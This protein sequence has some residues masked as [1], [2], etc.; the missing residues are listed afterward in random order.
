MSTQNFIPKMRVRNDRIASIL[1]TTANVLMVVAIGTLP[2]MAIGAK[3]VPVGFSKTAV[4]FVACLLALICICLS[5]LRTGAMRLRMPLVLVS[6]WAVTAVSG[7]SALLSGDRR[8]AFTGDAFEVHTVIFLCVMALLATLATQFSSSTL[9][10]L[11]LYQLSLISAAALGLFHVIRV[12]FGA[13]VLSFGVYSGLLGSPLG[14]WNDLAIFFGIVLILSLISL[15]QIPLKTFGKILTVFMTVTSLL[16]LSLVNFYAV[17]IVV[18]LF[19]LVFLIYTLT[20]DRFA[21]VDEAEG[22]MFVATSS[23]SVMSISL[24]AIVFIF[25]TM[26][27]L[28]GSMLGGWISEKT[29]I[30]YVE[31]RPSFT[32][33]VDIIKNI[34]SENAFTGIGPNKFSDAWNLYKDPSINNTIFWNSNFVSGNGYVMTWFA[35]AGIFGGVAWIIFFGLFIY[36]GYRLLVRSSTEDQF[37]YFVGSTSFVTALFVWVMAFWY[38]PGPALLLLGAFST[39]LMAAAT[40]VL[41]PEIKQPKLLFNNRRSGFILIAAVMLVMIASVAT[42]FMTGKQYASVYTYRSAMSSTAIDH[43]KLLLGIQSAYELYENDT[44]L[45]QI[46]RLETERLAYIASMAEP[47][48]LNIQQASQA[49]IN[50]INNLEAA[51]SFDPSQSMNWALLSNFY[52]IIA[53]T[54]GNQATA[55]NERAEQAINRAIELQPTN[56]EFQLLKAQIMIQRGDTETARL[57]VVK[58]LELKRDYTPALSL[59]TQLDIASGNVEGAITNARSLITLEPRNAGRYY[60]LG[61]LLSSNNNLDGAIEAFSQAIS[62]DNGYANARYMLALAL[63]QKGEKEAA[64]EQL[65]IVRDLNSDNVGVQALIDQINDGT[66]ET[67]LPEETETIE[68]PAQVSEEEGV[69]TTD[70]VP[71][72]DLIK[73]VNTVPDTGEEE[74]EE[75]TES[76]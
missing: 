44:Y 19:S 16:V 60:Q 31:V 35:T 33:T 15:E 9:M 68:E 20:K 43:E 32:A 27:I 69:V 55:A 46:G 62:L 13:D 12:F 61:I 76:Q 39:G 52:F 74:S 4:V 58:S 1:Q 64:V 49:S 18:G 6:L 3:Y 8:D 70:V 67:V 66:I 7:V 45:R 71:T 48:E 50:A 37:W 75:N 73:P 28:A 26:F 57:E 40:N 30:S 14:G 42:M 72:T 59:L 47:S 11:R 24:S 25:A 10:T 38:V 63:I 34:Y 21:S 56:P 2:I 22:E 65:V 53:S 5:V 29:G 36:S 41:L 23:N 51:V 17:W 54:G